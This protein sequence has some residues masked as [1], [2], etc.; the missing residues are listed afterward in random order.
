MAHILFRWVRKAPKVE[1]RQMVAK[2]WSYRIL[3]GK[4][5]PQSHSS[6]SMNKIGHRSTSRWCLR[7][8]GKSLRTITLSR[9]YKETRGAQTRGAQWRVLIRDGR[10][11]AKTSPTFC[12]TLTARAKWKRSIKKWLMTHLSKRKTSPESSQN[13]AWSLSQLTQTRVAMKV[14]CGKLNPLQANFTLSI[15][16]RQDLDI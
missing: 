11:I 13:D 9:H 7:R 4:I 1:E 5:T 2:M 8:R 3:N 10:A 15:A 12:W 6:A 14:Q 16:K